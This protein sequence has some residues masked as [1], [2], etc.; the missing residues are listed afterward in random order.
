MFEAMGLATRGLDRLERY[1]R[2]ALSRHKRAIELLHGDLQQSP[3]TRRAQ[4]SASCAAQYLELIYDDI[5][6]NFNFWQ[7]EPNKS[8]A[9]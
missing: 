1:E 3:A 4:A 6:P 2:R 8:G 5:Q 9:A 7:N